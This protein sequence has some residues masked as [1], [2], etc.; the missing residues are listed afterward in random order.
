MDAQDLIKDEFGPTDESGKRLTTWYAQGHSD[1]LGDR[2]LMFDNTSAPSWEI[3]RFKPDLAADARFET[4]L[5]YRVD[6][7][8]SFRHPAF[9]TVRPITELDLD[10]DLAVVSTYA[11]GVSLSDGLKK[12]R[13]AMFAVRLLRQ[14]VPAVAALQQH[15]PGIAHGAITLDRL[16]LTAEGRLMVREHMVGSAIERL[17]LSATTLWSEFGLLAPP[18]SGAVSLGPRCDVVQM[19]LAALSLM[20]GRRLGRDEYPD[21]VPELLDA[22]EDRSLWHEPE[23]FRSLRSWLERA[24][25]LGDRVFDSAVDAYAALSEL[26]DE[27]PRGTEHPSLYLAQMRAQ[28]APPPPP[29]PPPTPPLASPSTVSHGLPKSGSSEGALRVP[30]AMY[31]ATPVGR[32]HRSTMRRPWFRN[33]RVLRW[34]AAVVGVL[35]LGEAAFIGQLLGP[36]WTDR[37][38]PPTAAVSPPPPRPDTASDRPQLTPLRVETPPPAPAAVVPSLAVASATSPP[39]DLRPPSAIAPQRGGFR[40][41]APVEVHVLDGERLLGSSADGPIIATAGRHEFEFINSAIGYRARRVIDVKAGEI[42]SV[43]VSVPDGVLNIN[44]V[45]WAA[46]W[47]DG[48]SYGE[49]PLG[50][51]SIA[52]GEHEVVFRHPQFGERREKA[53]VR[54][55]TTTRVAVNFR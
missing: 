20:T 35:A 14:L 13:S 24:L 36:D 26:K 10:Q 52:P 12:P 1:A 8:S 48:T 3:L 41:S 19:A 18:M 32:A 5:R 9:P 43:S 11:S 17:Q 31:E 2:L 22:I 53:T 25:Q 54:A 49:T 7:L 23:T 29:A 33:A 6:Q 21:R 37:A 47:I 39:I 55:E 38:T 27:P 44:A 28:E 46:V 45:P 34:A 42:T 4:E 40:I 15:G 16:V 30:D 51:L 50:N